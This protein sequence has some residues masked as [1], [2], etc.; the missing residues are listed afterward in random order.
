MTQ[1]AEHGAT[2]GLNEGE[3]RGGSGEGGGVR[4]EV[5]TGRRS[6]EQARQSTVV[7]R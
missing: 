4:S 3:R 5:P 1:S 7:A 2:D 6:G